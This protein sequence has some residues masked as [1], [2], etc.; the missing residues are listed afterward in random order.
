MSNCTCP[1]RGETPHSIDCLVSERALERLLA[2]AP[3]ID[4][5]LE[6]PSLKSLLAGTEFADSPTEGDPH[7]H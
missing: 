7:A 5:N 6:P 4:P 2:T 1:S 3:A